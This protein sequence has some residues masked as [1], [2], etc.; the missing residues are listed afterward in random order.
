VDRGEQ[1][2]PGGA[3]IREHRVRKGN[4]DLQPGNKDKACVQVTEDSLRP[5]C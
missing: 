1:A 3:T 4:C 5:L 2:S